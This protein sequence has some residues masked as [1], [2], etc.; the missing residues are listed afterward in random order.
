[1]RCNPEFITGQRKHTDHTTFAAY[2]R[3]VSPTALSLT[4]PFGTIDRMSR[5][6]SDAHTMLRDR[7]RSRYATTTT[8][9]TDPAPASADA[10]A[11]DDE[12]MSGSL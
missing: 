2:I 7:N 1:M 5:M 11:A 12:W 4:V 6:T 10:P 8:R 3:N 9:T